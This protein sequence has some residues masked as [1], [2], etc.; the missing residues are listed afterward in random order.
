MIDVN[1]LY[2]FLIRSYLFLK[3]SIIFVT[4]LSVYVDSNHDRTWGLSWL[5][6]QIRDLAPKENTVTLVIV[7]KV[8]SDTTLNV[9]G[10]F[11]LSYQG[12]E[13]FPKYL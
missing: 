5:L 3:S 11:L 7:V 2:Y 13:I 10:T 12:P 9:F 4:E 1:I 8:V 6:H